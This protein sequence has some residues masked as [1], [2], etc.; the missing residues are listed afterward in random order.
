M[1][2]QLR[3]IL[4]EGAVLPAEPVDVDRLV[5]EAQ[6]R[7]RRRALVSW[8]GGLAAVSA[9]ALVLVVV[10]PAGVTTPRIEPATAPA[11]EQSP[12]PYDLQT[13]PAGACSKHLELPG[14]DVPGTALV[15]RR[16]EG[17]VAVHYDRDGRPIE[18][19]GDLAGV[20]GSW[21]GGVSINPAD[22]AAE[23]VVVDGLG[24]YST[25]S[26]GGG[27]MV[28]VHGRV[29]E[30]VASVAVTPAGAPAVDAVVEDG[31]FLVWWPTSHPPES[32]TAYDATGSVLTERPIEEARDVFSP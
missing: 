3:H 5:V 12:G 14:I 30:D 32:V 18:I 25:P 2:S 22:P 29:S 4:A 15:M 26:D 16:A 23:I 1:S 11:A 9:L 17:E 31:F 8:T 7:R 10:V 6:R 20:T 19:C 27:H 24:S 13:S 21:Y 28:Y